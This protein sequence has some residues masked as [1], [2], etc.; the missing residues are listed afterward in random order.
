MGRVYIKDEWQKEKIAEGL[1]GYKTFQHVI[2][3]IAIVD[4]D[5]K[6]AFDYILKMHGYNDAGRIFA[7]G[8]EELCI[9]IEYIFLQHKKRIVYSVDS[10]NLKSLVLKI[11]KQLDQFIRKY[12]INGNHSMGHIGWNDNKN[13]V[14]EGNIF[15]FTETGSIHIFIKFDEYLLKVLTD[16][17][18][19]KTN[20]K[21]V[22]Q[23]IKIESAMEI[24]NEDILDKEIEYLNIIIFDLKR[25]IKKVKE[26]NKMDSSFDEKKKC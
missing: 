17:Y 9:H 4:F 23:I 20:I 5:Y 18:K 21:K 19:I 11:Y 7:F 16:Y 10:E 8:I 14:Y 13:F 1:V 26:V 6:N 12:S 24:Y 25:S 15:K 22:L 3:N 2:F